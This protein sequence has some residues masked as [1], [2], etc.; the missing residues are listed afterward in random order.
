[1]QPREPCRYICA[2]Q[3][4]S[5]LQVKLDFK[6]CCGETGR[7]WLQTGLAS[8]PFVEAPLC[9]HRP[10]GFPPSSHLP[11]TSVDG[12]AGVCLYSATP[13]TWHRAGYIMVHT[14]VV[15]RHDPCPIVLLDSPNLLL[16]ES[17]F[18]T[19]SLLPPFKFMYA[20]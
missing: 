12:S 13:S 7:V 1:M 16:R 20:E 15:S 14:M 3:S 4:H 10:L 8:H 11:A 2:F 6:C 9:S 17:N 19:H 18:F 5:C